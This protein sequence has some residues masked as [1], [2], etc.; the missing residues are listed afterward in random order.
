MSG[1]PTVSIVTPSYN[2]A[3]FLE[4]TIRSVLEQDY[5]HIEYLVIDGGSSDGSVDIIPRFESRLAYWVSE[6]DGGQSDAVNRGWARSRGDILAF[7]N[8]DDYLAPRAVQRVVNAFRAH[9]Q[10][11]VVYGQAGWVTASGV[12][13]Q[14]THTFAG[15]QDLL[16][17]SVGLPQP[18][19][20]VHRRVIE[21]VGML[22]DTLHY[23]LDRDFFLRAAGNFA[24]VPL[25]DTLAFMRTHPAAKHMAAAEGFP[26]EI[27]RVARKVIDH[28]EAY[29]R[30]RIVPSRVL[31]GAYLYS[32]RFRYI[33]GR[34]RSA[35]KDLRACLGV[36]DA[37]RRQIILR[38]APRFLFRLLFGRR[39]YDWGSARLS[40][41]RDLRPG[42][43]T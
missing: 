36:S 18:A 21:Q 31:A 41:W 19:A 15:A 6:P 11:G 2:Q 17:P 5:P 33:E 20:F 30:C 26:P 39:A 32:G 7:L 42:G 37:Y 22:D 8:S 9:P 10:A 35:I 16:E 40:E 13:V 38:D 27:I 4:T 23:A 29:P 28:P 14:K 34:Y 43:A 3:S 1:F 12:I 25:R 24:V